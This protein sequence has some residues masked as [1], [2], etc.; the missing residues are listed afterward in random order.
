MAAATVVGASRA[1]RSYQAALRRR[2]E[3]VRAM[4]ELE[5]VVAVPAAEPGWRE[6]LW[7]RVT[8]LRHQLTEHVVVTEGPEGL[9]AELLEHAP[10][11]HRPMVRLVAEHGELLAGTDA[12]ARRLAGPPTSIREQ[13]GEL[14][15]ALSRH[16]QRGADLVYEAYAAD[17]GGET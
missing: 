10:R 6:R 9:Y 13:A 4:Q 14:L 17:I 15:T 2:A 8:V 11:L 1:G 3:L 16:R 7:E 12:L 5:L